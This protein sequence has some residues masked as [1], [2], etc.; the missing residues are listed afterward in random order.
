[1]SNLTSSR[2][3]RAIP[4]ML[5]V[6]FSEAIAYRA[7]MI[8]WVLA[9]T[10]PLIMLVVWTA[11][12]SVSPVQSGRTWTTTAFMA[13]FLS[14][15]VVRQLVSAWACWEINYEVRQG[16]LSTR[17]LRPIHPVISYMAQ[18]VAFVPLRVAVTLP[19]VALIYFSDARTFLSHSSSTWLIWPLTMLG[20]WFI[21]FFINILIGALSFFL[22]SSIKLMDVWFSLF[23]VFSGYLYPLD[24]FPPWLRTATE[25]L[26]FRYQIAL[27]VDL[28]MGTYDATTVVPLLARQWAWAFGLMALSLWVWRVGVR[29]F[30]AYGG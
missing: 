23:F 28:I 6:G 17:L 22:E 25:W 7:E 26:P 29:R 21:T 20:A 9:T 8:I 11:V 12:A 19:I 1:M 3:V 2:V 30:Q 24:L 5:R 16:V 15:F 10:M 18:N 4:T 14:V 27:P 13:Y